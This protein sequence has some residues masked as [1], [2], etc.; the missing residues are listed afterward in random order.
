MEAFSPHEF[1]E[2]ARPDLPRPGCRVKLVCGP[3][4][5]GKS[6]YV[7]AYAHPDDV[8]I[9][10]D[11]IAQELGYGRDRPSYAVARLLDLRNK[12]L[13]ALANCSAN[14][15]A[16]VILTAPSISLRQWW[17]KTLNVQASDLIVIA[18]TREELYRRIARD[19][20]RTRVRHLHWAL[21]DD[22]L[23]RERADNAGVTDGR[24]DA[25]GYPT[26]PLHAWNRKSPKE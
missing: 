10:L 1:V 13:A 26:D 19:P 17:C 4:A 2:R 9:D 15:I 11:M 6:T 20:T 14:V 18:P 8:V 24:V 16:W 25:N 7:K 22:W 5:A 12:R 3:P 21:V 23:A